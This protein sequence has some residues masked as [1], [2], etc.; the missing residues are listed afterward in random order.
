M[1]NRNQLSPKIR[2]QIEAKAREYREK[3]ELREIVR[4]EDLKAV[5]GGTGFDP[6]RTICGWT[7]AELHYILCWVYESYHKPSEPG[8]YAKSLTI[9]V[10]KSYIPSIQWEHYSGY[11]YP[12]FIEVPM[13]Y[14]WSGI[15]I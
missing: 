10:A 2:E 15:G 13:Y 5:T 9:E 14:L 1:E 4:D 12:D 8:D 6:N 3:K 11:N 7:Y